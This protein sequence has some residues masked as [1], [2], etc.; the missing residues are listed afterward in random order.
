MLRAVSEGAGRFIGE[1]G[2]GGGVDFLGG[3]AR[4]TGRS[5]TSEDLFFLGRVVGDVSLGIVSQ[6]KTSG[7]GGVG[8]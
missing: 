7:A 4:R 6:W 1:Q 2:E 8:Q 3:R 5:N